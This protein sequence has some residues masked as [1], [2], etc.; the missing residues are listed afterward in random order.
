MRKII[1][2][3]LLI[4]CFILFALSM[5]CNTSSQIT[6]EDEPTI[7]FA[8]AET[9]PDESGG[10]VI[11]VDNKGNIYYDY[12]YEPLIPMLESGTYSFGEIVGQIPSQE[13]IEK[14]YK[15]CEIPEGVIT[16]QV[17]TIGAAPG[18]V[19][20]IYYGLIY[21]EETIEAKRLW[22]YSETISMLDDETAKDI[23][24]WMDSWEWELEKEGWDKET[25]QWYPCPEWSNLESAHWYFD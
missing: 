12:L 4:Q 24:L 25:R 13:V 14:Y 15:F 3:I 5:G 1:K 11:Y 6:A 18:E 7:L 20:Q 22:T 23:I 17:D 8:I 21:N 10:A 9:V 16:A 19:I 2:T